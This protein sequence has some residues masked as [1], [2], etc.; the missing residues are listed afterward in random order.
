MDSRMFVVPTPV[1]DEEQNDQGSKVHKLA[2]ALNTI[3]APLQSTCALTCKRFADI[4]NE[5][6]MHKHQQHMGSKPCDN[7]I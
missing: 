4:T 7:F 1:D 3:A 6:C 5:L 2:P